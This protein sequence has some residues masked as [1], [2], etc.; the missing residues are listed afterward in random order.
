MPRRLNP[1]DFLVAESSAMRDVVHRVEQLADSHDPVLICGDLGTGRELVG[2]VLHC[3][4]KRQL[5]KFIRIKAQ[6][7]PAV[8]AYD[9]TLCTAT[10]T[11]AAA[12]RGTLFIRDIGDVPQSSQQRLLELLSAFRARSSSY[13]IRVLGTCDPYLRLAAEA[14]FFHPGLYE[15]LSRQTITLPLLRDRLEDIPILYDHFVRSYASELGRGRMTIS[16]RTH[17]RLT[18]YPWPGN[19]AE[20]KSVARRVVVRATGDRIEPGDLDA[21]LPRVAERV[22]LERLSFEDM[23]KSKLAAFLRSVDGYPPGDLYDKVLA[24]V[25]RPLLTLIMDRTGGNQ[26]RAAEILGL[27]RNTLRR[28][29]SERGLLVRNKAV[30]RTKSKSKSTRGRRA[31]KQASRQTR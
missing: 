15:M 13:D 25:E 23:V 19:V 2:R 16:S 7:A 17:D 30:S 10:Q 9:P 27:N 26:V 31:V 6:M 14:S 4:G 20:L 8:L 28:K 29:L 5:S 3:A 22:P 18:S 24:R 21:V 11:L 12:H 1:L